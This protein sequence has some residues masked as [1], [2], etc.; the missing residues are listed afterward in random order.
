L[1]IAFILYKLNIHKIRKIQG[2]LCILH[3][4]VDDNMW[5]KQI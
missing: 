5:C 4:G 1:K 2:K 3:I